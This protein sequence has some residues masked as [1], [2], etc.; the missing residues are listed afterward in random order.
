MLQAGTEQRPEWK[1]F[2]AHLKLSL[3]YLRSNPCCCMLLITAARQG[4]FPDKAELSSQCLTVIIHLRNTSMVRVRAL[5]PW[6]LLKFIYVYFH[7]PP[8]PSITYMNVGF[9]QVEDSLWDVSATVL[10]RK[11]VKRWLPWLILWQRCLFVTL[12]R[13]KNITIWLRAR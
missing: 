7:H 5:W 8:P 13:R 11:K 3:V 10:S 12:A 6:S 9:T 1:H 4:H 2:P